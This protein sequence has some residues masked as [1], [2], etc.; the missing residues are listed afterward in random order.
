MVDYSWQEKAFDLWNKNNRR[1]VL[2]AVPGAGKTRTGCRIIAKILEENPSAHIQIVAPTKAIL[3]QWDAE[4]KAQN[5]NNFDIQLIT[6]L[7]AVKLNELSTTDLVVFDECHSLLSPV[8]GKALNPKQKWVLGLSATPDGAENIIGP[9]FLDIGWDEANIAPFELTYV[10]FPMTDE[11]QGEYQRLTSNI[12]TT[13]EM[14]DDDGIADE[15]LMQVIMR[16]RDFVYKLSGRIPLAQKLI[17]KHIG[18]KMMVFC[19]RLD[20]VRYLSGWLIK[21]EINHSICTA[22]EDTIEDFRQNKTSILI[23]AKMV[24]EG[25]NDPEVK[26]GIIVS[27]SLSARNQIQTIGRITRAMPDK[28]AKLYWFVA[29]GTSDE[30]LIV[31]GVA[32]N[33]TVI[34]EQ[35]QP[36]TYD[37][38]VGKVYPFK[39]F[40]RW[41]SVDSDGDVFLYG[42][43]K[44]R[45]YLVF[46]D[47]QLSEC[48]KLLNRLKGGGRFVITR[49]GSVVT[50]VNDSY[51]YLGKCNPYIT[52]ES[53]EKQGLGQR[54]YKIET[55]VFAGF[56]C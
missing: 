20:Q 41:Y 54:R 52:F 13:N 47:P 17:M 39:A 44:M 31:N 35:M 37:I 9:V 7:R 19:E 23:S 8:R 4:I 1:G 32:N 26:I 40:G 3:F 14:L 12:R 46:D 18:T 25:Y 24:R 43:N 48:L 30:D 55:D 22:E 10:T 49:N 5:L 45:S 15:A 34:D 27:T 56:R 50:K 28:L 2:R 29:R 33:S 36:V 53:G 16:R 11:E 51:I 38:E 21:Q 42:Q 6:Y